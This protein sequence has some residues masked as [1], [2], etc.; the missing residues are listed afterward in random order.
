MI[1]N[2]PNCKHKSRKIKEGEVSM[3]TSMDFTCGPKCIVIH[4]KTKLSQ[5]PY[6]LMQNTLNNKKAT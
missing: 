1:I 6:R 4:S 2:N 3:I 5:S